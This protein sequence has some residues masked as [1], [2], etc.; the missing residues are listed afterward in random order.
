MDL[1]GSPL[2]IEAGGSAQS[3]APRRLPRPEDVPE[4]RGRGDILVIRDTLIPPGER[5]AVTLPTS[6]EDFAIFQAQ[7]SA[8]AQAR[9]PRRSLAGRARPA[10]PRNVA[11]ARA[12]I[13][14]ARQAGQPPDF[15]ALPLIPPERRHRLYDESVLR[16]ARSA[17]VEAVLTRE[18]LPGAEAGPCA[19][20]RA[21]CSASTGSRPVISSPCAGSPP[22][23][24]RRAS[25]R[26][27]S[28][29]R[30][31]SRRAGP[32]R[33]GR[34]RRGG[35]DH[36]R[37]GPVDRAGS[38]GDAGRGGPAPRARTPGDG[39]QPRIM[40]GLY[41]AALR[42]GLPPRLVGQ[43]IML[44][45]AAHKLD[46][47][48]GAQ[49]AITLVMSA[50]PARRAQER[51][52]TPGGALDRIL[53][54]GVDS[55][56]A[57][58]RCYVYRPEPGPRPPVTAR[59]MAAPPRA[60]PGAGGAAQAGIGSGGAAVASSWTA[61]S[62]SNPAGAPMPATRSPR[63]PGWASSSTAPGCA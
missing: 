20:A 17:P 38:S 35:D 47:E 36:H 12:L 41:G 42:Q 4:G 44:L 2:R 18:G 43:M 34:I 55:E 60:A 24:D 50:A 5:L 25:C 45:S 58:I 49:D 52:A 48:A 27:P 39:S 63:P 40:D 15:S 29:S 9:A 3:A 56:T 6:Q 37:L 31:V 51:T 11:E 54:I 22:R 21:T 19:Q 61:S 30:P 10:R 13:A 57:P 53:Y 28:T 32:G 33:G 16:I 8:A 59:A 14:R 62:R 7:R 46:A 26:R 23:R 1:P